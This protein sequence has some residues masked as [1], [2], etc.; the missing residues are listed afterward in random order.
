MLLLLKTLLRQILLPPSSLLLLAIVGLGMGQRRPRLAKALIAVGLGLLWLLATPIVAINITRLAQHYPALDPDHAD[1]AEAIVILGGGGQRA[2]APEY[3]GPAAD[4]E[5]LDK[6]VYGAYLA[7]RTGLPILVSGLG[8]EA[9][10]MRGTLQR[11][12]DLTPRWVDDD[13]YDTF[14]NARNAAAL[15]RRDGIEHII[16]LTRATHMLRS[17]REFTATGLLVTPAPVG[18]IA[19]GEPPRLYPWDFV[20]SADGLLLSYESCYELIGEPVRQLFAS[21]HLRRQ[22]PGG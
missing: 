22:R 1:G 4:S 11:N 16:L 20:P 3:R 12:F 15:L 2:W 10:A 19:A 8:F 17:V 7:R 14:E 18:T 5:L 9:D 13:A 21:L 6:L